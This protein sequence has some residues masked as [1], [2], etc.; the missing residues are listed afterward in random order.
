MKKRIISAIL[1][2]VILIAAICWAVFFFG[3]G[4]ILSRAEIMLEKDNPAAAVELLDKLSD[5]DSVKTLY[6]VAVLYNRAG[7]EASLE[8]TVRRLNEV[9]PQDPHTY[10]A[11]LILDWAADIGERNAIYEEAKANGINLSGVAPKAPA[12]KQADGDVV[13]P[14]TDVEIFPY[15]S[16]ETVYLEINGSEANRYSPTYAQPLC[17]V[18]GEY[19]ISAVSLNADGVP[20]PTMTRTL[21]VTEECAVPFT[22]STFEAIILGTL[23]EEFYR[24]VTNKEL[25]GI[26]NLIVNS[27]VGENFFADEVKSYH[28]LRYFAHLDTLGIS[29]NQELQDLSVLCG[30]YGLKK[31]ALYGPLEENFSYIASL[32]GLTSL[33]LERPMIND[34]EIIKKMPALTVLRI[35]VGEIS[36][37]SE[38]RN[39][40]N[41]TALQLD[42]QKIS[43]LTPVADLTRL[44]FLNLYKN[45]I[46]DITPLS[47]LL[48]LRH[49]DLRENPVDK[50]A[51]SVNLPL[52]NLPL[53]SILI[54]E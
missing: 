18:Y 27:S 22:D 42:Y 36:D 38:L 31:F 30:L 8:K 19:P 14:L 34:L 12:T 43:D 51:D 16:S 44:E 29:Q 39:H 47:G 2:L 10:A 50:G 25:R 40:K 32:R 48:K 23:N 52:D 28:D 11:R 1:V 5:S 26:T 15:R 3:P 37:L 41:L 13:A 49:L 9:A 4:R 17:A 46:T 21:S 53:D 6:R 45:E 20:S 35:T 54:G 33:S 7:D 24:E